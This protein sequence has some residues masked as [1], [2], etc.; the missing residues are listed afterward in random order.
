V[1][2]DTDRERK[3]KKETSLIEKENNCKEKKERLIDINTIS[4]IVLDLSSCSITSSS[5]EASKT[6]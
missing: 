4:S 6:R 2:I 1:G 3:K 5:Q